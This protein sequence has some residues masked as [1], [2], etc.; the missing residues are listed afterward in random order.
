ML[1]FQTAYLG[2]RSDDVVHEPDVDVQDFPFGPGSTWPSPPR[3]PRDSTRARDIERLAATIVR[4]A[5]RQGLEVPRKPWLDQLPDAVGLEALPA[6]DGSALV[7]G[8]VDLPESQ[9][10]TPFRLDLDAAGNVA[11]LGAG[12]AGK[13]AAL[14]APWRWRPPPQRTGS[15][16]GSPDWTSAVVACACSRRCRR[17]AP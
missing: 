10:Q 8:T 15:R 17:W 3:A 1:D 6:S 5:D 4:A 14:R 16:S 12:G 13:S 7:I 9:R 2:G 11:V